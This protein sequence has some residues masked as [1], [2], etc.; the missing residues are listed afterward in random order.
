MK[1]VFPCYD[2]IMFVDD[3]TQSDPLYMFGLFCIEKF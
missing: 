1:K 3:E 2:V